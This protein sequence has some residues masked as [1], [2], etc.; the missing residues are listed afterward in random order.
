MSDTKRGIYGKFKVTRTDGSD[1]P[2]GKHHGCR[3]FV[4]DLD[5]D[6][7]AG[8]AMMVYALACAKTNP[9]LAEDIMRMLGLG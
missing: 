2:G 8:E 7:H 1:Q 9:D 5:H 3:Y 4:L 6:P